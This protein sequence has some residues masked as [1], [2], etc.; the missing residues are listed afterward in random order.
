MPPPIALQ[1]LRAPGV[2]AVTLPSHSLPSPSDA[3]LGLDRVQRTELGA[4]IV[5]F[6]FGG[7]G[8]LGARC[9]PGLGGSGASSRRWRCHPG[10]RC[11]R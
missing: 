10:L 2:P 11:R 4:F 6:I 1:L 7:W 8:P 9:G 3:Y 5:L